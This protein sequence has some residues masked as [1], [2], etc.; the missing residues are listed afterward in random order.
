MRAEERDR[1]RV[2]ESMMRVTRA[3]NRSKPLVCL[4]N[5]PHPRAEFAERALGFSPVPPVDPAGHPAENHGHPAVDVRF[6]PNFGRTRQPPR[7]SEFDP[8]GDIEGDC[9]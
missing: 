7:T 5:G 8:Q 2:L 9:G 1:H 6:T 3:F 4:G